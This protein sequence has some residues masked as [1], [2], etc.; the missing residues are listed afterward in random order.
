MEIGFWASLVADGPDGL[1]LKQRIPDVALF[2][3]G[4]LQAWYYSDARGLLRRRSLQETTRSALLSR[5]LSAAA[6]QG[7]SP[8]DGDPAEVD[9]C[10][11]VAILRRPG[12]RPASNGGGVEAEAPEPK[13]LLLS[14][15]EVIHLLEQPEARLHFVDEAETWSLQSLATPPDDLRVVA[16]YSRDAPGE[17]RLDLIGRRYQS[18]YCLGANDAP[19]PPPEGARED[20]AE[21][22]FGANDPRTVP[23]RAKVMALVRYVQ[24][25]HGQQVESLIA[26]FVMDATNRAVLHGFWNVSLLAQ[27]ERSA[28]LDVDQADDLACSIDLHG[29][30]SSVPGGSN[31]FCGG[32]ALSS[33]STADYSSRPASARVPQHGGTTS[34][35]R[36]PSA[37][38]GSRPT[39]AS[40]RTA[41]ELM[42]AHDLQIAEDDEDLDD[43]IDEKIERLQA[44]AKRTPRR[45]GR[46]TRSMRP[47]EPLIPQRPASLLRRRPVSARARLGT[48]PAEAA[49]RPSSNLEVHGSRPASARRS[50]VNSRPLPPKPRRP[51]SARPSSA[52]PASAGPTGPSGL[53]ERFSD[54]ELE[55]HR[56]QEHLQTHQQLQ[57]QQQHEQQRCESLE[58]SAAV[59]PVESREQHITAS[60]HA[61]LQQTES[62]HVVDAMAQR[63]QELVSQP[64]QRVVPQVQL[65]EQFAV[66]LEP[67]QPS[68]PQFSN[69]HLAQV[70]SQSSSRAEALER[71]PQTPAHALM[72]TQPQQIQQEQH[73]RKEARPMSAGPGRR[74]AAA[75]GWASAAASVP[76]LGHELRHSASQR[77]RDESMSQVAMT[78]GGAPAASSSSPSSPSRRYGGHN[79]GSPVRD[80]DGA[81]VASNV[82]SKQL[83]S[84][85]QLER[86]VHTRLL[87]T[88]A[89]Q[90][91]RYRDMLP[92]WKEQRGAARLVSERSGAELKRKD[93]EAH[94][95]REEIASLETDGQRRYEALCVGLAGEERKALARC[96]ISKRELDA[97]LQLESET[98][99][100]LRHEEGKN[101]ASRSTLAQTMAQVHSLQSGWSNF[102]RTEADRADER[103]NGGPVVERHAAD[104]DLRYIAQRTAAMTKEQQQVNAEIEASK[105][106]VAEAQADLDRQ[107]EYTR[108][109]ED[110]VRR[111]SAVGPGHHLVDAATRREACI[112]LQAAART[113]GGATRH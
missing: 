107:R 99:E 1:P 76:S 53:A 91:E 2:H 103:D 93:N 29:S 82:Y 27:S 36:P 45:G 20:S 54:A 41:R 32:A 102:F 33:V 75:S 97:S 101:F 112:A 62:M 14:A 18:V 110:F 48:A 51:A 42:E 47:Q 52:R 80:Q 40:S 90:L 63:R 46:P 49:E 98:V 43:G 35:S 19:L 13:A 34:C 5:L 100:V 78:P 15:S 30:S 86:D 61:G 56:Q 92:V 65:S 60:H 83:L 50:S 10:S 105:I 85:H 4:Q 94:A 66:T 79:C 23:V 58:Q 69:V 28:Y 74:A 71:R 44:S 7:A 111:I 38:C 81:V 3:R 88:V 70:D 77:G 6:T 25:F 73:Q 16:V 8:I 64:D 11:P 12:G 17:E 95:L 67:Q 96:E 87:S 55:L 84:R 68:Q 106:A 9:A 109:L 24:H 31:S 72:Q 104:A 57:Q 21:V 26:E 89:R 39:S 108:R 59:G 37:S 113:R 22:V